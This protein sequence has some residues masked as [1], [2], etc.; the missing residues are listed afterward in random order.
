MVGIINLLTSHMELRSY[1]IENCS[2]THEFAQV[3]LPV[4]GS[5]EIELGHHAGL[6][7]DHIGV[8]IAPN[9]RHCFSGS[10][11]NLFLVVDV[12]IEDD[13]LSKKFSSHIFGLTKNVKSFIH[14]AHSY[15]DTNDRDFYTDSL[16]TQ[17]MLNFSS[18]K[19]L[20]E[21]DQKVVDAKKW[22]NVHFA[23]PVDVDRVAW[24]CHLSSSQLQRRFKQDTGYGI[25]E[26]W[27]M[28]KMQHAKYLLSFRCP[29]IEEI[30]FEM[31]YEN[32]SAFSRR[33]SEVFGISPSQ[34]RKEALT[35]KKMREMDK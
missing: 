26:Y 20:S 3:V 25:A 6:I 7:N 2:H 33:F 12:A 13:F 10:Q 8:Y 21:S 22:I 24:H 9:D 28:K 23:D 15:L 34:W 35:A 14:F 1:H 18:K 5:M 31:G 17:L 19:S 11:N 27:R 29:S 4:T 16:I 32:L 30:A